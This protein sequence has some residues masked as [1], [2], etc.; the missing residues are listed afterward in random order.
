[1]LGN[2]ALPDRDDAHE[3]C[4]SKQR[5]V[6]EQLQSILRFVI[7]HFFFGCPCIS[8][9]LEVHPQLRN[10]SV[11]DLPD[12][13]RHEITFVLRQQM[14]PARM[15]VLG[16]RYGNA[17]MLHKRTS[18]FSYV[19][20]LASAKET[21]RRCKR[22]QKV[23]FVVRSCEHTVATVRRNQVQRNY[24]HARNNVSRCAGAPQ[25]HPALAWQGHVN[26]P[27]LRRIQSLYNHQRV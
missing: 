19:A 27:A 14:R 5:S 11:Q 1:M 21:S 23:N 9:Y 8:R 17:T 4:R 3:R 13:S 26:W 7:R 25:R 18:S 10:C 12:R 22:S 2:I 15:K 24:L 16:V 20:S 6:A